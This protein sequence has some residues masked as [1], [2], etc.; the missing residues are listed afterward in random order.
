[1]EGRAELKQAGRGSCPIV[2]TSVLKYLD[3]VPPLESYQ[4][5]KLDYWLWPS[6]SL[7]TLFW[8]AT[9]L[10][11]SPWV[12]LGASPRLSKGYRAR[13]VVVV[14]WY[15]YTGPEAEVA[16][17]MAKPHFSG[18]QSAFPLLPVC[19]SGMQRATLYSFQ[20]PPSRTQGATL[21]RG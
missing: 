7:A 5:R 12:L 17:K 15:T 6:S 9:L 3:D 11:F 14:G 19:L 4:T 13:G 2:I 18:Y 21:W 8:Y 1:M 10:V 20:S 16:P